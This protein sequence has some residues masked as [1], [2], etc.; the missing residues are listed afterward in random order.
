MAFRILDATSFYAG[1]PFSSQD[2]SFTTPLVFEEIKHI[3][4]NQD[5]LRTLVELKR[6]K[7]LEPEEHFIDI[8]MKKSKQTGD[9]RELSEGDISV[10]ALCLQLKGDLVT[11]DYAV[12]N[13][14]KHFNLKV[15]PVMTSGVTK[16]LQSVYACPACEKIFSESSDCPICGT[17]LKKQ[18]SKKSSFRPVHK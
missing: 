2:E 11:D 10:I 18:S 16:V 13:V 7:I 1:I 5:V 17:K 4:S 15:I 3:K 8:V 12:S 6:L 9:L 14:A